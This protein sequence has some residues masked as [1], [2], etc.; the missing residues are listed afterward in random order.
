MNKNGEVIGILTA[1]VNEY[2]GGIYNYAQG[3]SD[4]LPRISD[5]FNS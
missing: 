3:I 1:G 5:Y 2:D 4:I